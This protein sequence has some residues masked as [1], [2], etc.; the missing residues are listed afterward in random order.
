MRVDAFS[1]PSCGR[2]VCCRFF[3]RL[4]IWLSRATVLA[5]ILA[6]GLLA[7]DSAPV[8]HV[9]EHQ[10]C[11]VRVHTDGLR[12]SKGLVGTLLFA[13]AVGWPEDVTKAFRHDASAIG[14][15]DRQA[16]I[17]FAGVPPGDYGVVALHHENRD[18]KLDRNLFGWPKEGFGFANNPRV[19]LA[20]PAFKDA[21][22]HAT[23]PVT[24]TDIHVMYK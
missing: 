10:G 14:R 20:P 11:T 19:G 12:N 7:E 3:F 4:T 1:L 23:C 24:S 18:M 16:T 15:D 8:D 6:V 9:A 13:S 5:A 21:I 17:T 22:L 2:K